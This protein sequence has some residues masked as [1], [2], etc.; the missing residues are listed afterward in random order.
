M[1]CFPIFGGL[2]SILPEEGTSLA[3][4][5]MV[6]GAIYALDD[7]TYTLDVF[8]NGRDFSNLFHPVGPR[9]S[10]SLRKVL[11]GMEAFAEFG[12]AQGIQEG[13]NLFLFRLRNLTR[14]TSEEETRVVYFSPG[15]VQVQVR[16]RQ[17]QTGGSLTP[18]PSRL[19]V[20]GLDD[21]PT[22]NFSPL[23][24]DLFAPRDRVRSFVNLH[25]GE[26]TLYLADGRYQ[27][28]ASRGLRYSTA[29]AIIDASST[30][31]TLVLDEVAATPGVIAADCHVH[32]IISGDS[33]IPLRMR[34]ASFMATDLD[35][36]VMTDHNSITDLTAIF[37][38][39]PGA[40]TWIRTIP[41]M[42]LG[43]GMGHFN[44]WPLTSAQG[45]LI[46]QSR[47]FQPREERPARLFDLVGTFLDRPHEPGTTRGDRPEGIIT[48]NHPLGIMNLPV[49]PIDADDP[50]RLVFNS[51]IAFL[52]N[53]EY[54]PDFP[55]PD[56]YDPNRRQPN[57]SLRR[58]TGLPV[59]PLDL[60]DNLGFDLMEIFN[61]TDFGLYLLTRDV[62]F[63]WLNQGIRRFALGNTDSHTI[64]LVRPGMPRNMV[65]VQPGRD[66]PATL[67]T[68]EVNRA[69]AA[70]RSYITT[71]PLLEVTARA[72]GRGEEDRHVGLGETLSTRDGKI[73]LKVKIT[74]APWVPV[75][76][77]RIFINGEVAVRVALSQQRTR[78]ARHEQEPGR[79]VTRLQRSFP[80]ELP[81]GSWL[82]VEAG[83]S[84]KAMPGD[85]VMYDGDY[86]IVAPDLHPLAITNPI[87]IDTEP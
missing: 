40:N 5:P 61:R 77:L 79:P 83:F 82:V 21:T 16:V 26:T 75:E 54:D 39:F 76:E 2:L 30:S 36:A 55:V 52:S 33:A 86:G 9:R 51:R 70:G 69:L 65:M 85:P 20:I 80:L 34:L 59:G 24:P 41:G 60:R 43:N 66:R 14:G 42:E 10:T 57:D 74:A 35:L 23:R 71:G 81:H 48:V 45:E 56:S 11:R 32:S 28:L 22:P 31:V 15:P 6:A 18:L 64:V 38:A 67:D 17:R 4:L 13:P 53:F 7:D 49:P 68:T 84:G 72:V 44:I 25:D 29:R 50:D 63:S 47:T 3:H 87:F 12:K 19:H 46:R 58:T 37:S 1:W 27:L 62:W 73:I 8:L 78:E